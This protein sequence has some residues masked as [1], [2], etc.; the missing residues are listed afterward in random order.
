MTSTRPLAIALLFLCTGGSCA[1]QAVVPDSIPAALAAVAT[2]P[3]SSAAHPA[4]GELKHTVIED[5]GV[6]I[7]ETRLR[8][9]AQRIVVQSKVGGAKPYEIVVGAGGRDP[10]QDRGATGQSTWSLFSY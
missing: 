4:S 1:A 5:K 10:S 7:E 6:R 8:G 9:Q 3:A 2:A